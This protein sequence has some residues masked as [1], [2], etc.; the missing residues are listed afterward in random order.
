[1]WSR[2]GSAELIDTLPQPLGSESRGR[3]LPSVHLTS[4]IRERGRRKRTAMW[5]AATS[6]EPGEVI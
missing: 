1:M 5:Y 6:T 2:E 4:A 3:Q